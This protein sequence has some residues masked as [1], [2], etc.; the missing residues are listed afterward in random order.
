MR[1]TDDGAHG[2]VIPLR[3]LRP[4]GGERGEAPGDDGRGRTGN[5]SPG[6]DDL[7]TRAAE[8]PDR[9]APDMHEPGEREDQ[10]DGH[11]QEQMELEDRA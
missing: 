8:I 6:A 7:V 11:A 4:G 10:E 5:A 2:S 9:R 3:R 1:V